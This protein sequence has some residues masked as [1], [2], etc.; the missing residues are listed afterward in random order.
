V[1]VDSLVES[2]S[3]GER[4]INRA[5]LVFV[6]LD[7]QGAPAPFPGF[8]PSS[9][10]EKLEWVRAEKRRESRLSGGDSNSG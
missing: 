5:Y 6:A 4:L 8:E 3:G 1:R 9:E 2:L 10:E 7:E